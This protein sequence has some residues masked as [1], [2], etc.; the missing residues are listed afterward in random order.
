MVILVGG[1]GKGGFEE[2]TKEDEDSIGEEE[3]RIAGGF[4]I[5]DGLG[6]LEEKVGLE[7]DLDEYDF[8]GGLLKTGPR[9]SPTM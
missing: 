6:F 8:T 9:G 3:R 5:V 1:K 7:P 2:D 4:I